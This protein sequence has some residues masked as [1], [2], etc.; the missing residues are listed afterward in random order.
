MKLKSV[1]FVSKNITCNLVKSIFNLLF[2][3][4]GII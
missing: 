1:D 2:D 3:D 4:N